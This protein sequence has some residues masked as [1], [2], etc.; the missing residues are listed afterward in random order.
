MRILT[1]GFLIAALGASAS[2]DTAAGRLVSAGGPVSAKDAKGES[3]PLKPGDEIRVGDSL[4]TDKKAT[5]K[6]LMTDHT[7]L[8]LGPGSDFKVETY[9]L[10]GGGNREV[11]FVM[12]S[13]TLRASVTLPVST[14]KFKISTKSATMGVRGTE[15]VVNGT[16]HGDD[17]KT[18]I[19][20]LH[21]KVDVGN[22]AD[23]K[24][25]PVSVTDGKQLTSVMEGGKIQAPQVAVLSSA[26]LQGV[27][28]GAKVADNTFK[29]AVN[30]ENSGSGGS[31]TS[32]GTM[33]MVS[34]AV[35]GDAST[36]DTSNGKGGAGSDYAFSDTGAIGEY[37]PGGMNDSYSNVPPLAEGQ[38]ATLTVVFKP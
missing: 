10:K 13:G 16:A 34:D 20:V 5:A 30:V 18:Q 27:A 28:K 6:L 4:S 22:P 38:P 3:R 15:F 24:A 11:S 37:D 33:S 31:S 1:P 12:G 7:I 26:Q 29:Q 36:K 9:K 17:A 19:T 25:P 2:A 14:G 35:A 23:P 21:G 32:G 8:D